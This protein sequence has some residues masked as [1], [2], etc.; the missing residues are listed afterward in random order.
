[1]YRIEKSL[2]GKQTVRYQCPTCQGELLSPLEDAG[3]KEL[4]PTCGAKLNVPGTAELVEY[5]R[6]Q[7]A[8]RQRIEQER[9]AAAGRAA[10]ERAESE[11]A[12]D[13]RT[14]AKARERFLKGDTS[15]SLA[16]RLLAWA[17]AFGKYISIVAV[18]LCFLMMVAALLWLL[19]V[20]EARPL[21]VVVPIAAPTAAEYPKLSSGG[22]ATGGA[23]YGT[24]PNAQSPID[25]RRQQLRALLSKHSVDGVN[26]ALVWS[27][28]E[29]ADDHQFADVFVDG[30]TAFIND[31]PEPTDGSFLWYARTF[32]DRLR[33][34][35]DNSA[36]REAEVRAARAD[37]AA[38]RT[39]GVTI[40]GMTLATLLAFLILPLLIL[41]EE[42]T[43][44]LRATAKLAAAERGI[45]D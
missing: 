18:A 40:I 23:S 13:L 27:A 26:G 34:H 6:Q 38:Q 22:G 24:V 2:L 39:L 37:A 4:C 19:T 42:N 20:R 33:S 25:P 1:V 12:A 15:L 5:R 21:T 17:F 32:N 14:Q 36:R 35:L 29:E 30:L 43:R 45:T 8:Q 3:K 10:R 9:Q 41:I 28:Y 44:R 16:D 11:R 7:A 31:S